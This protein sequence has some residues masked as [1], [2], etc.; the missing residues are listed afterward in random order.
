MSRYFFVF[1]VLSL[2]GCSGASVQSSWTQSL[3]IPPAAGDE[4]RFAAISSATNCPCPGEES[5]SLAQCVR[6]SRCRGALQLAD[7]LAFYMAGFEDDARALQAALKDHQAAERIAVLD[8]SERPRKGRLGAP[9]ELVIFDDF[10]CPFCRRFN[11]SLDQIVADYGAQVTLV[12]KHF[13]LKSKARPIAHLAAAAHLQGLFWPVMEGLFERQEELNPMVALDVAEAAGA[14]PQQLRLDMLSQQIT[15]LVEADYQDGLRADIAG[16]PTVYVNGRDLG[17]DLSLAHLQR[18]VDFELA[19]Q[20]EERALLAENGGVSLP[21]ETAELTG[22]DYPALAIYLPMLDGEQQER[23]KVI[24][25]SELCPCEGQVGS[26]ERCLGREDGGCFLAVRVAKIAMRG[27]VEDDTD[28]EI[29]KAMRLEIES[30]QKVHE[31][32]LDGRPHKGAEPAKAKLQVVEFADYRCG[33]CAHANPLT[34]EWIEEYPELVFYY[35]NF[36]LG[37][38]ADSLNAAYA[39]QAALQQEKF[40]EMHDRL[41]AAED[42]SEEAIFVQARGLGLDMERF[43]ADFRDEA[44][45]KRVQEDREDG[46]AAGITGTPTFF[47]NG[48]RFPGSYTEVEQELERRLGD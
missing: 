48:V 41:F 19:L 18:R 38:N 11:S 29:S 26:L 22:D 39:S 35:K 31:F 32:R 16:T 13:P 2:A 36:P 46:E 15:S 45:R 21:V 40:W 17:D 3:V 12:F 30:A 33:H 27:I 34:Q 37:S 24:L 20:R 44:L 7:S 42:L 47:M 10:T 5:A 23:L 9:V 25:E 28:G 6:Q 43:E 14:D 4:A 1:L 8:L